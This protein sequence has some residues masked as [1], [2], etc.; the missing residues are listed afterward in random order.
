MQGFAGVRQCDLRP[1]GLPFF[2]QNADSKCRVAILFVSLEIPSANQRDGFRFL[3]TVWLQVGH[4]SKIA[5]AAV[6]R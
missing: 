5:V 2:K 4:Q 3:W 1:L 6:I